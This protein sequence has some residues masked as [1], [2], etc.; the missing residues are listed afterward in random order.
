MNQFLHDIQPALFE[1]LAVIL[2]SVIS[3]VAL[4]VKQK[5]NVDIEQKYQEDLHKALLSGAKAAWEKLG[6]SATNQELIEHA[7]VHAE[8]SV[9]DAIKALAPSEDVLGRIAMSKVADVKSSALPVNVLSTPGGA[10]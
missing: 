4:K 5:F 6:P 3:F 9:P 10:S 8:R 1:L 7:V 2:T